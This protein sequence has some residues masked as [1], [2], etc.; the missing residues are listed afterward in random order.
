M[1]SEI[2][3]ELTHVWAKG[4]AALSARETSAEVR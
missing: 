4:E 1:S 3:I 2:Y